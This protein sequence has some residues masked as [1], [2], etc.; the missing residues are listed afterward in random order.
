MAASHGAGCGVQARSVTRA[1]CKCALAE[2]NGQSRL[3][4]RLSGTGSASALA[5]PSS[6][7][8]LASDMNLNTAPPT[9]ARTSNALQGCGARPGVCMLRVAWSSL[10]RALSSSSSSL[11]YM[12]HAHDASSSRHGWTLG[13]GRSSAPRDTG[14]ARSALS[15]D[16][17]KMAIPK[18]KFVA[19]H[20]GG[21]GPWR[22][23]TVTVTRFAPLNRILVAT[24]T[25]Q[26]QRAVP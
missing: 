11:P 8:R 16:S 9:R 4:C 1:A 5:L 7:Q 12:Y 3:C 10:R 13:S 25:D 26:G 24:P 22:R 2:V 21:Y 17:H 6:D 20:F 14:M 19:F 23:G 15:G 18:R